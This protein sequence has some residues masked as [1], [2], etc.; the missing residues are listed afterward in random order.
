MVS[1]CD[2]EQFLVRSDQTSNL[3]LFDSR[4]NRAVLSTDFL[5]PECVHTQ[6][7][8]VV[9]GVAGVVST[10]PAFEKIKGKSIKML[11]LKY[12]FTP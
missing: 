2:F 4:K 7:R 1:K 8:G 6:R 9:T 10:T 12:I 5:G 3:V 11:H